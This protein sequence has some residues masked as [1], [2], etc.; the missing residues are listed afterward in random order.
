[1]TNVRSLAFVLMVLGVLTHAG[2]AAAQRELAAA[3]GA[4]AVD[5]ATSSKKTV[6]VVD[7]TDLQGSVTE[8]GRFVAEEMALGLVTARAGLAVVDRIHV[9]VL[10]REHKLDASGV[11]APS[12][13]RKIGQILGAEALVTGTIT[14]FADSVRV[15]VKVLDTN[16]ARI[17]AATSVDVSK[18]G[19]IQELL[20]REIGSEPTRSGGS[21]SS[22]SDPS[23]PAVTESTVDRERF[24]DI[25][26]ERPPGWT[27][28]PQSRAGLLSLVPYGE[29]RE[30]SIGTP[31]RALVMIR[32]DRSVEDGVPLTPSGV[33]E[34]IR[35]DAGFRPSSPIAPL[36][37]SQANVTA[38]GVSGG[39]SLVPDGVYLH[40]RVYLRARG[41]VARL[42]TVSLLARDTGIYNQFD[43]AFL[44]LVQTIR[45]Q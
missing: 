21:S 15:V 30:P 17:L 8:L 5:I 32:L 2:E 16:T 36:R 34:M 25:L 18:N 11:T 3:A 10:L 28:L 4:I 43:P 35:A 23:R 20:G 9:R 33:L 31:R 40:H 41:Q 1:M 38:Y 29:E 37:T 14:P 26:F 44:R 45:F 13:V 19:T 12:S 6:A 22:P 7:F 24:E 42:V 27:V 39:M